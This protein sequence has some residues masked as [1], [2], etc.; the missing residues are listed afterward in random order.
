MTGRS[1]S[2]GAGITNTRRLRELGTH[3]MAIRSGKRPMMNR[4]TLAVS[5]LLLA[6]RFSELGRT[7]GGGPGLRGSAFCFFLALRPRWRNV[8]AGRFGAMGGGGL[9][10]SLPTGLKPIAD[11]VRKVTPFGLPRRKGQH[12]ETKRNGGEA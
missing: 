8:I 12:D 5:C 9:R 11:E 2:L 7:E 3:L 1:R 6:W 4:V 10:H